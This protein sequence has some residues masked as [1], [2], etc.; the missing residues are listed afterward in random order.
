MRRT[1]TALVSA[2]ALALAGVLVPALPASA[3]APSGAIFT[4]LP[5]GSEVNFNHF[6]SKYDVYLDGGPGPGAPQTAAGLDDGTY[7]FQITDPS[8]KVL[9]STDPARCRQFTVAGGIITA[10]V[11]QPDGCQH[12]TGLDVDHGAATVQMMPY[13]DTP[14]NGGVYKAWATMVDDFK[15]GCVALGE[16]DGLNVV[17]CGNT[18]G[19]RHGFVGSDS[20]TDNFKAGDEIAQEIDTRFYGSNGQILDGMG[21]TWTDTHGASNKKWSYYAPSLAVFHEAHVENVEAGLHTIT[22]ANQPGCAVQKVRSGG[23]TVANGPGSVGVRI[24][25]STK[26]FTIFVDVTC[27]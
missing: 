16:S 5:D 23:K 20:K 10:V 1:L 21:V 27:Y 22:I 3:D 24:S 7:V 15:A 6:D 17:D 4:T 2:S 14:N 18:G 8:G 19:N 9:L 12:L 13:L 11:A 25:P 26:S